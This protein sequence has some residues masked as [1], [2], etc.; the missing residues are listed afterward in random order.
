[1]ADAV[2]KNDIRH[3]LGMVTNADSEDLK[4]EYCREIVGFEPLS[5]L[6]RKTLGGGEYFSGEALSTSAPV[7]MIDF[8]S[9]KI[10]IVSGGYTI[11][12]NI[13][14][15]LLI[16]K[17]TGLS[18]L[19]AWDND[20]NFRLITTLSQFIAAETL[21]LRYASGYN[22]PMIQTSDVLRIISGKQAYNGENLIQNG[23]IGWID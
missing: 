15:L 17:T 2:I 19:Y 11:I 20:E 22:N 13:E 4:P 10:N 23:W 9:D 18:V 3:F 1:M 5:T 6:L 16:G 12:G 8:V 14:L 7:S 21:Y